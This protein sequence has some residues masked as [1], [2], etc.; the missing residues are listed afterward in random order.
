MKRLLALGLFLASTMASAA[1]VQLDWTAPE[2]LEDGSP[3]GEITRFN[4]Y[5]TSDSSTEVIE[6]APSL[7]S[8]Q[9]ENLPDGSYAFQISTVIP[10]GEDELEGS[11]SPIVLVNILAP[12]EIV[13]SKPAYPSLTVRVIE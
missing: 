7:T 3:I 13:I 12:I 2:L 8:Y 9:L 11:K 10:D 6:V 5:L 4:I 1:T